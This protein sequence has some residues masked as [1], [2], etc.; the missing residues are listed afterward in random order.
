[1]DT[2]HGSKRKTLWIVLSSLVI[3][4]LAIGLGVW[5]YKRQA[6]VNL[7]GYE[8][9]LLPG[10]VHIVSKE[11]RYWSGDVSVPQ[12]LITLSKANVVISEESVTDATTTESNCPSLRTQTCQVFRTPHHT[13]YYI[14]TNHFANGDT[15]QT[16]A[17]T[18]NHTSIWL[19]FSGH[20]AIQAY[21]NANWSA[22]IDSFQPMSLK[23]IRTTHIRATQ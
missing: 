10:D 7:Q 8:P 13:T 18:R 19:S 2:L 3:I 5:S 21:A 6:H 20:G 9:T 17:F 16:I 11:L 12:I 15:S 22:I 23:D 1:M 14:I 4:T